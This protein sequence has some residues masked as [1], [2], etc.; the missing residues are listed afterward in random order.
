MRQ[1]ARI[2]IVIVEH[3]KGMGIP[4]RT[5]RVTAWSIDPTRDTTRVQLAP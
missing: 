3:K 1:P 2:R 5:A 4:K